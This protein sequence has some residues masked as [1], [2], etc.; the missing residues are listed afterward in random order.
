MGAAAGDYEL[1]NFNFRQDAA[2]E[3]VNDGERS[4]DGGGSNQIVG[5]GAI[6]TA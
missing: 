3:S 5:L 4:E 2:V 6:L 1:V